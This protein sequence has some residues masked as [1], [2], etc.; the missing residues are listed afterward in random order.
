MKLQPWWRPKEV[1]HEL[2][3]EQRKLWKTYR[4]PDRRMVHLCTIGFGLAP[5]QNGSSSSAAGAG[6]CGDYPAFRVSVLVCDT[7]GMLAI[8]ALFE[9]PTFVLSPRTEAFGPH[10]SCA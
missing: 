5:V 7:G 9:P 6:P 8:P 10:L 3:H 4:R 2:C 1:C